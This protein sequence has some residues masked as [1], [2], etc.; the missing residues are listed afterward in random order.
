MGIFVFVCLLFF[1]LNLINCEEPS[2]I[3]ERKTWKHTYTIK[4]NGTESQFLTDFHL[5][6]QEYTR[7]NLSVA[8]KCFLQF[9][10]KKFHNNNKKHFYFP[11]NERLIADVNNIFFCSVMSW[12]EDLNAAT[13]R[14]TDKQTRRCS[15]SKFL[16]NTE[17]DLRS[18]GVPSQGEHVFREKKN[19]KRRS[20]EI[21]PFLSDSL[22]VLPI[23][24]VGSVVAVVCRSW[25]LN[26][27]VA[28]EGLLRL[29]CSLPLPLPLLLPCLFLLKLHRGANDAHLT[30]SLVRRTFSLSLFTLSLS[31]SIKYVKHTFSFLH[32]LSF[33]ASHF[34]LSL[35]LSFSLSLTLY[36][37][38]SLSPFSFYVYVHT[39]RRAL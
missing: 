27:P 28:W 11:F 23:V 9:Y 37:S 12:K 15:P 29:E 10:N 26:R 20:R 31:N 16:R 7:I 19:K 6:K 5:F 22:S 33:Y 24:N 13:N 1:G 3:T 35:Y 21:R 2:K 14:Q 17:L 34:S 4:L 32:A 25:K 38:L 18:V 36:L 30:L 8:L 39:R